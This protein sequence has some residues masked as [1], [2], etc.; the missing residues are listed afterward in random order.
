MYN[1]H[2]P[3]ASI[4]DDSRDADEMSVL[5]RLQQRVLQGRLYCEA[6]EP[7]RFLPMSSAN[8]GVD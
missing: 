5:I 8:S 6:I 2:F 7:M 4:S 3:T 1:L